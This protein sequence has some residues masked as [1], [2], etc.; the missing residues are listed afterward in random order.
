MKIVSFDLDYTLA[1][2]NTQYDITLDF[3]KFNRTMY[4]LVYCFFSLKLVYKL[5]SFMFS[6]DIRRNLSFYFLKM[7]KENDIH[8]FVLDNKELY[9]NFNDEVIALYEY[10]RSDDSNSK[11][12]LATACPL[13]IAKAFFEH[14][15]F[16][17][18]VC[19]GVCDVNFDSIIGN[20]HE[21]INDRYGKISDVFVSDNK[22]DF[23]E[24]VKEY[25]LVFEGRVYKRHE[26]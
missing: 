17:E 19:P 5:F 15:K 6:I 3:L 18:L 23:D 10:L 12:I 25:F 13:P 14:L 4:Y 7:F 24:R 16:D 20:K 22:E 26:I 21:I 1:S 8:L 9:F 2:Y 11:Y